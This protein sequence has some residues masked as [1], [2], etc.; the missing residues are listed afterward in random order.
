MPRGLDWFDGMYPGGVATLQAARAGREAKARHEETAE[1]DPEMFTPADHAALEGPWSW[2]GSVVGPAMAH[3]PGGLIDDD[4]AYV[5]PWG[6]DP[7]GITA[8]VLLLHGGQDRIVPS[9]HGE[10]LAAA[11]PSSELWLSPD[12]GPH[13]DPQQCGGGPGMAPETCQP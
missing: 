1:F 6:F 11:C 7:A 2:L 13:L 8:P 10:W 5:A 3:G 4:L 9:S 12:D